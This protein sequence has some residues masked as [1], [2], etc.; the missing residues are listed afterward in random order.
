MSNSWKSG[1]TARANT[2]CFYYPF[3]L[4]NRKVM[5]CSLSGVLVGAQMGSA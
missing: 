3:E 4:R 5:D 1:V 2:P